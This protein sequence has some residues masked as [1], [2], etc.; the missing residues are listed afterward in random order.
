MDQDARTTSPDRMPA[1][2]AAVALRSAPEGPSTGAGLSYTEREELFED[3]QPLVRRLV[4]QYGEDPELRQ[5]LP[6]EIYRR[7]CAALEN[8]DPSRGVP[9]R[10]YLV[11]NLNAS[12]YTY[13]RTQ[14]RRRRREVTLDPELETTERLAV[15]DSHRQWDS[16]VLNQEVVRVLPEA[17]GKLSPRQRAV[18]VGR[19]YEARSFEE[20][21]A[22][23]DICPATAR[24]LLRHGLNNLRRQFAGAGWS[25][26]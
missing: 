13:V 11:C 23:L 2:A 7:Y 26:G 19:F 21:A 16:N 17:I 14:W 22:D 8:Y 5:D 12:V 25:H 9:L 15:D 24:S 3:L 1:A 6:G 10:A 4:R 20:I 18:V